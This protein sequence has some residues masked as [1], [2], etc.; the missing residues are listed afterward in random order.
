[1]DLV[2]ENLRLEFGPI[3]TNH[4]QEGNNSC[5]KR[6]VRVLPKQGRLTIRWGDD[7]GAAAKNMFVA[8]SWVFG[9]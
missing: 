1:M 2:C 8:F 4:M 3:R 5:A 6:K 9:K 7:G